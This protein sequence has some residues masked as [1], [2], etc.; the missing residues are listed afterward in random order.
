MVIGQG[1]EWQ[2]W[3]TLNSEDALHGRPRECPIPDGSLECRGNI[4]VWIGSH[5]R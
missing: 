3:P 2:F 1:V 4:L 5:Q